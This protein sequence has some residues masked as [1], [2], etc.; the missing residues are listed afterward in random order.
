MTETKMQLVD[1]L[2]DLCVRFI[3]NLP[4]EELESVE[5]ICFQVEE[6]QWFYEDFVRP[7]DPNLPSLNLRQFCFKIFQHCPLFSVYDAE[8]HSKAFS[9][10]LAYKTR[11]PVRG[12]ILLN[13]TLDEVVLVKGYKKGSSWSFPR[14]KINKDEKDIDCAI[15]EVYEETGYD[16]RAAGLVIKEEGVRS[17]DITMREQNMKL[18]V[19]PGVPKDTHFEPRTRKEISK[20]EWYRLSDLPTLKKLK[21]QQQQQ[22]GQELARNANKFYMVAPFLVPLKKY[23]GHLRKRN[24]SISLANQQVNSLLVR[25]AQDD[26][27][28]APTVNTEHVPANNDMIRLMAQLRQS[29]QASRES[30]LPEVSEP[31][32][33]AQDSS[34]QLKSLLNV[35]S[36]SPPKTAE[37]DDSA[38]SRATKANAML[39]LLRGNWI[40]RK[41][42]LPPQTPYDQVISQPSRP[43]LSPKH[44]IA[45]EEYASS[46]AKPPT[47]LFPPAQPS[48]AAVQQRRS[49]R[50]PVVAPSDSNDH[51]VHSSHH[52]TQPLQPSQLLQKKSIAPYAAAAPHQWTGDPK[53]SRESK[54]AD[55]RQNIGPPASKLPMPKL[56]AHSSALLS[57]FREPSAPKEPESMSVAQL[58][59]DQAHKPP[60]LS[61]SRSTTVLPS[62]YPFGKPTLSDII[63]SSSALA[64]SLPGSTVKGSPRSILQHQE[65]LLNL[66]KSPSLAGKASPS[67]MPPPTPVELAANQLPA[68]SDASGP[69]SSMDAEES[70]A[71]PTTSHLPIRTRPKESL[72]LSGPNLSA[73]VTG[74]LNVPQFESIPRPAGKK[75]RTARQ[76][77]TMQPSSTESQQ[78]IRILTRPRSSHKSPPE[79]GSRLSKPLEPRLS[80]RQSPRQRK[81]NMPSCDSPKPFQPQILKR[82]VGVPPPMKQPVVKQ[83]QPQKILSR[84]TNLEEPSHD[85]AFDQRAALLSLFGRPGTNRSLIGPSAGLPV[86][87]LSEKPVGESVLASPTGVGRSRVGSIQ[88]KEGDALL[89]S[90][91][92]TPKVTASPH[93]RKFLLGFLDGVAKEGRR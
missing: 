86:S 35:S 81:V 91:R 23:I 83:P 10:F 6:A 51:S 21:H 48:N 17:I 52:S 5:R 88:S 20:I 3:I 66:F 24:G 64:P 11:V 22:N 40:E 69:Q 27:A 2:D 84:P 1:W 38:G 16:I 62:Y 59:A 43:P 30:N 63:G 14:G 18:F 60:E 71:Q 80:S 31:A 9:E 37:A 82:P 56:N 39:S 19:F 68:S 34:L 49:F 79:T 47:F 70:V 36:E 74:P 55:D 92:Q 65:N 4:R 72:D 8:L 58:S 45:R 15:R 87:P 41:P 13:D 77:Q 50:Q 57:L 29:R 78:P 46:F 42:G 7:L 44:H 12:A 67:L 25:E 93:D 89:G 85:Q 61:A 54:I 32:V 90:G 26:H 76:Q 75:S 53:F 33:P 28:S 73:T